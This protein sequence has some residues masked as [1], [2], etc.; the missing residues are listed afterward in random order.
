M[1]RLIRWTLALLLGLSLVPPGRGQTEPAV[2]LQLGNDIATPGEKVFLPVTL[3][4]TDDAQVAKVSLEISFPS[5]VLSFVEAVQGLASES[6]EAEV[7]VDLSRDGSQPRE[8]ILRVDVRSS[9][10]ISQGVLVTLL[11]QLSKEAESDKVISLKSLKQAAQSVEGQ[12]LEARGSD[13]SITVVSEAPIM[14]CFFY[15]H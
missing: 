9:K 11:F 1:N 6:A 10:A 13:G 4:T 5:D 3:I 15:M 7:K 2:K 12:P 14:A 8:G